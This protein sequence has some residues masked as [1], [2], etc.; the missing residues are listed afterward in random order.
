MPWHRN[1]NVSESSHVPLPRNRRYGHVGAGNPA[2]HHRQQPREREYRGVQAAEAQFEDLL[3]QTVRAPAVT[4]GI[5]APVGLQVGAGSRIV[6][7]ARQFSQGTLN[8]TGNQLDLA[9]QGN[10]FFAVNRPTG[11]IAYTRAGSLQLDSTGRLVTPGG[12][13]LDPTITVPSAA[14]SVT[15]A[16]TAR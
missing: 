6:A 13:P 4:A 7:T 3:Y 14:T 11:D 10:G 5:P 16:V 1:R 9:I 8:Q 12:L 2:R 15:I